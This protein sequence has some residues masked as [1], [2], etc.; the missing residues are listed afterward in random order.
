MNVKRLQLLPLIELN[1]LYAHPRF[2]EQERWLYLT[3][4]EDELTLLASFRN[5]KTK[6]FF[7]LQLGYFRAK[8]Q[9]FDFK[10]EDVR[11]DVD[12]LINKYF[13][14]SRINWKHFK[15][16]LHYESLLK[17]QSIILGLFNYQLWSIDFKPKV[18]QQTVILLRL[19]PKISSA[20]RQL[21]V[22]FSKKDVVIPVYRTFQDIFTEAIAEEELRLQNCLKNLPVNIIKN[23][24]ELNRK[25]DGITAVNIIR[26]DQKSFRYS[27]IKTELEKVKLIKELYEF[28]IEFLPNLLLSNNVIQH[29]ADIADQYAASRL[30]RFNQAQ[31][32]LHILCFVNSRYQQLMDNLLTSFIYHMKSLKGE[33]KSYAATQQLSLG[34]RYKT[35]LPKLARFL[36]WFPKRDINMSQSQIDE[37]AYQILPK[38]QF[39]VLANYLNGKTFD[40]KAALW[41]FYKKSIKKV[42]LYLRPIFASVDWEYYKPDGLLFNYLQLLKNHLATGKSISKLHLTDEQKKIIPK[43]MYKHLKSDHDK[44]EIDPYLFEW[45][46]YIKVEHELTRGRLYCNNSF[47]YR[48][49]DK[50]LIDDNQVEN[51]SKI[52]VE[53][54]YPHI[55]DYCG[56]KLNSALTTLQQTW[57]RTVSNIENNTN[58]G[59]KR[60]T[61]KEGNEAWTLLYDSKLPLDDAF[62]KHLPKLD[63]ASIVMFIGNKIDLWD[64]FVHIKDRYVKRKQPLPLA[65][66]ACLISEACG[67]G[68]KNMAEVSDID[69]NQLRATR[70]DF[71]RVDTLC[72]ANDLVCNFTH[73]L[74][75]FK[76]WNLIEGK[77]L[78][79]AD[80]Q[81]YAT[82]E[83]NIQS[84]YSRKHFGKG[85][86]L[87][88]NSMIANFV[89]V[90]A[91]NMSL[92]EYEGHMLYDMVS[93]NNTDITVDMVTGDNHSLNKL[94]FL[95][96]NSI[97]V[98]FVPCIRNIKSAASEL[99]AAE[100]I[101][102]TGLLSINKIVDVELVQSQS[103]QIRKVLLSLLVQEDTQH[104]LI[105]KLNS[106]QRYARLRAALAEYNSIFKSIHVL[107]LIDDMELRKALRT[108]RNRTEAYHQMHSNIRK[109]YKGVFSGQ[110]I[111]DNRVSA[112]SSRLVANCIIAY[113]SMILNAVYEKMIEQNAPESVIEKFVR[114]SPIAWSH[115]LFTGRYN[116]KKSSTSINVEAMAKIIED[117][118][119][120]QFWH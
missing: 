31:Q 96:L 93:G 113:N 19:Y 50:D 103:K 17:Q 81:K 42:A 38:E 108:A 39:E 5:I 99:C 90:V 109:T 6:L 4:Q 1:E 69:F 72:G 59:L 12:F 34:A 46:V 116:F 48:D 44:E 89:A 101:E 119:K 57:S 98:E 24:N 64:V 84:R 83:N 55:N 104:H 54:G 76:Q 47:A 86:G 41:E 26:S 79:D 7:A 45:F 102:N 29:Y 67:F 75:L 15:G 14:D 65:V 32:H 70:E 78:A 62:F 107:N 97:N 100:R 80:G 36:K 9:F 49:I 71:L 105:R 87:S 30:R 28:S 27:D 58:T 77:L 95:I 22:F 20:F 53:L 68:T 10:L 114:I 73:S 40:K 74:P 18:L 33:A 106:H 92:N 25:N 37:H 66:T 51:A 85:R 61:D 82:L 2:N 94:N 118:L 60:R 110:R 16:K 21:L 115:T 88:V 11:E 35:E 56:E 23:L 111:I 52:A 3:L 43:S 13:K 112:Q 91:H 117:E 63:I 120:A 8:Q